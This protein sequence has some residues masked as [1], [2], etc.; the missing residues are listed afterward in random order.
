MTAIGL[1]HLRDLGLSEVMLY[2][3]DD[4]P[5]AVR[6]YERLGFTKW[7]NDVSFSRDGKDAAQTSSL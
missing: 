5:S 1:R 2:V 4:N 7:D 3:D 6:L